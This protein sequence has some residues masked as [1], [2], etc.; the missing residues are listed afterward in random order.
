MR[1]IT[2]QANDLTK[3]K[4]AKITVVIYQGEISDSWFLR[5]GAFRHE[6]APVK[7]KGISIIVAQGINKKRGRTWGGHA[8]QSKEGHQFCVNLGGQVERVMAGDVTP[9]H[10]NKGGGQVPRIYITLNL[11]DLH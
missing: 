4:C 8:R 1:T 2:E 10:T 9:V 3:P 6:G 11:S 5:G 7:L